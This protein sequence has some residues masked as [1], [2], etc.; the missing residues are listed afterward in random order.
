MAIISA[1]VIFGGSGS[2]STS[3]GGD[4]ANGSNV[5]IVDGTQIVTITAIGG[6]A[7]GSSVAQAG[8]PTILRFKTNNSYDCSSSIRIASLKISQEL[9]ATGTTDIDVGTLSAGTLSGTCSMGMYRFNVV[10]S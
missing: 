1:F 9:P 2:P 5:Q 6:Y 10:A 8:I 3:G 7:P 4:S